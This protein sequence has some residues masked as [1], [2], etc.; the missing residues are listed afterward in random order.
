VDTDLAVRLEAFR[1]LDGRV[2][3]LGEVLP[4]Q[5]LA[6]GFLFEGRRVPLLGPQ[7]IFKP[8]LCDLP[9]SITT[10][11]LVEGRAAPYPDQFEGNALTYSYRGEDLQHRDNAGLRRAMDAH[12]PLVYFFGLVPSQYLAAWP[13]YVVGDDPSSL[14]FTVQVDEAAA[15]AGGE[16]VLRDED[17]RRSYQTRV[18]LQRLH[19]ADFRQRVLRAYQLTCAVCRLRHAELLDA[20]HILPDGHPRGEP[21]VPNGLALCKLHHAAFDTNIIGIRPDLILQVRSD[22]LEEIDGPM[23]QHALQGMHGQRITVPRRP[24]LQPRPAFLE[25]RYELFQ[26]AG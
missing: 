26:R 20:A 6:D 21:I 22:V 4:R 19:Q 16:L 13:V 3:A 15:L 11:P 7:G 25:E 1:F 5:L 8:A 12:V 17:A 24:T 23:L 2:R 10:V 18:V 14:T 9:L